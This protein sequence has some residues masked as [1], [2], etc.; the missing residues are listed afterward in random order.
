MTSSRCE[1]SCFTSF[2]P[3]YN[4]S[5][6]SIAHMCLCLCDI[7]VAIYSGTLEVYGINQRNILK[8]QELEW[9]H[10][11]HQQNCHT[12]EWRK[13]AI[14]LMSW[15]QILIL[16][17]LRNRIFL[18]L[19]KGTEWK[20]AINYVYNKKNIQR[21]TES[22]WKRAGRDVESKEKWQT[23]FTIHHSPQSTVSMAKETMT[24]AEQEWLGLTLSCSWFI[25]FLVDT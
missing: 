22:K 25:V 2:F 23:T 6:T 14:F 5:N 7:L 8:R 1:S 4:N 10:H 24:M 15:S 17:M 16:K 9:Q 11:R 12:N 19:Q 3:L 18:P 20:A 21:M 13:K